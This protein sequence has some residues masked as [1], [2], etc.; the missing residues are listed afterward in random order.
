MNHLL[1][2]GKEKTKGIIK[3][4]GAK[5]CALSRARTAKRQKKIHD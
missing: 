1:S 4:K 3:G 5:I 2:P